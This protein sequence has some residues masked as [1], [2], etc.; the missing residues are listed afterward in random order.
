MWEIILLEGLGMTGKLYGVPAD[1]IA[2]DLIQVRQELAGTKLRLTYQDSGRTKLHHRKQ[3]KIYTLH[4][5][6]RE[7]P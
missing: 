3:R 7:R 2:D 5:I 1:D 4:E 6:V